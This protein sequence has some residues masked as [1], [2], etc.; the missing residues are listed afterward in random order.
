MCDAV[1]PLGRLNTLTIQDT[2]R[3]VMFTTTVALPN[4]RISTVG[5]D[6]IEPT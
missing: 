1:T 6:D 2:V 5:A 3:V 4:V